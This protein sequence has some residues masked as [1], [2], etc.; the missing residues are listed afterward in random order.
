MFDP[1]CRQCPRLA[2]FLDQVKADHPDYYARPVPPFGD[3]AARLLIVG[4]APGMH[5]ANASGRPFT[6]DYA[7]ILL[8]ETLHRFGFGSKPES[9][10]ADDDLILTDCRIT[11]A[12]K[13]LPP[14]NKPV[15]S[16]INTCNQYLAQE[17][18]TVPRSGVI[19]ALGLVAHNAVLKAV[20][21][22]QSTCKFAHDAHHQLPNG[23][24]LIDSY[25]CSRYNTQT[26]RL[27]PEMFQEVFVHARALLNAL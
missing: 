1:D 3:P 21:L 16:E 25:H 15:G 13:C 24:Q 23:L 8:Y 17:L 9:L 5:G 7:G 27:T 22:K 10:S 2:A 6:G 12:V 26:R 19:V 11:N 4:L 18:S 14:Q 20:G